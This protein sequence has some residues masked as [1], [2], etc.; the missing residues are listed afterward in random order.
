MNKDAKKT[1]QKTAINIF[2]GTMKCTDTSDV[3]VKVTEH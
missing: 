2:L 3:P 1:K